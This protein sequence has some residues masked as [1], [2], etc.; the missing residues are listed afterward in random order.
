[1]NYRTL[2]QLVKDCL[3]CTLQLRCPVCVC[4]WCVDI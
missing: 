4:S 2:L 3:S 1:M